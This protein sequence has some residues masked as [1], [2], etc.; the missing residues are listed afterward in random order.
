M[1]SRPKRA[2]LLFLFQP[3]VLLLDS[4]SHNLRARNRF[5]FTAF[6]KLFKRLLVHAHAEH[7]ILGI[8]RLW[9]AFFGNQFHHLF[10][11]LRLLYAV[12]TRKS[13]GNF[14][15]NL[16]TFEEGHSKIFMSP[17]QKVGFGFP[18]LSCRQT[19]QHGEFYFSSAKSK[20]T[21]FLIASPFVMPCFSQ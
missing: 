18:V 12:A 5:R 9:S 7:V 19:E 1:P 20:R 8:F 10:L 2:L 14:R 15:D 16:L 4:L 3:T 11:L 17:L 13:I 21:P 6:I